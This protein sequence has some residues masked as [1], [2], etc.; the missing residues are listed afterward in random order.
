MNEKRLQ[1]FEKMLAT[2]QSEYE[3]IVRQIAGDTLDTSNTASLSEAV[4][5]A[6]ERDKLQKQITQ[7]KSR[8]C[9]EKQ[10]ARQMELR[11]EIQQLEKEI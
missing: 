3:N 6:Q 2:V 4:S 5:A 8:M 9:K 1:Q 7:L 11:R 10:L